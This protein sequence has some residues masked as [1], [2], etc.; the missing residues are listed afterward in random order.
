M[1]TYRLAHDLA[2]LFVGI[3]PHP[4]SYTQGVP[5]AN[6][7]LFWYHLADAG[8][9][10]EQRSELQDPTFLHQ[11]YTSRFTQV[12]RYAIIDIASRPSRTA[13][14]LSLQERHIGGQELQKAILHYQPRLVCFVGKFPYKAYN[15]VST[16]IYGWQ[17]TL[18]NSQLYV[19]HTPS[20][21]PAIVRIQELQEIAR[22]L[23]LP[24][25]NSVG[26]SKNLHRTL[27]NLQFKRVYEPSS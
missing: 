17:N 25:Y 21:G 4:G 3:N 13:Q 27:M 11:L 20:R 6:T 1:I 7:K 5:F 15:Q 2:I 19:M 10:Q 9:L 12:Y 14:E 23:D 16:C 24:L 8:L 18:G 22:A 26:S